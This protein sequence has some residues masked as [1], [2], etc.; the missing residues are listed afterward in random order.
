MHWRIREL[1][2]RGCDMR[3]AMRRFLD[4]EEFYLKCLHET[5]EAKR[6]ARIREALERQDFRAD[7]GL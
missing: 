2:Q 1:E 4:D 7:A 6:L 3:G 5:M